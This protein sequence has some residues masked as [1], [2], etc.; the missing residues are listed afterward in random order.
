MRTIIFA[1]I[2]L[3]FA[4]HLLATNPWY[5]AAP[6][7]VRS[8]FASPTGNGGYLVNYFNSNRAKF[9]LAN[10][11]TMAVAGH[12]GAHAVHFDGTS[13]SEIVNTNEFNQAYLT[14]L[15]VYTISAWVKWD[16]NNASG[17]T[18]GEIYSESVGRGGGTAPPQ[19]RLRVNGTNVECV[20]RGVTNTVTISGGSGTCGG[21]NGCGDNNW[22]L[23][24]CTHRSNTDM[25]GWIGNTSGTFASIGTSVT[26]TGVGDA[27]DRACLGVACSLSS[28]ANQDNFLGDIDEAKVLNVGWVQADFTTELNGGAG[29]S[30]E[31]RDGFAVCRDFAGD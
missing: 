15:S 24:T 12:I 18:D 31:Q 7:A 11:D 6:A 28:G 26:N 16:K 8:L 29:V 2:V 23:L 21:A 27:N 22:H 1:V 5:S 3:L 20:F 13:Y 19:T 4:R 10:G 30:A 25:Q 9:Y 14:G 17:I